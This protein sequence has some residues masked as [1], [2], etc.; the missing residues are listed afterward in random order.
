LV[1]RT[2][3]PFNAGMPPATLVDSQVTPIERFFVRSHAPAPEIDEAAFRLS[4]GGA[5]EKTLGLSLGE[6]RDRFPKKTVVATLQCAGNRRAEL[7][8]VEPINDQVQ[9]DAD[10]IGNAEWGGVPLRE[11]LQAAGIGE[12]ALHAAFTGLDGV[13]E[14]GTTF[15][16]GG[17]VPIE[18][19][20]SAEVLLA[21]EMNGQPLPLD[22]GAP[23]R[24]V[25]PGYIGARSVKWL[26]SISLQAEPS[27]N[28]YQ[29]RAYKI[30][31]PHVRADT[32]DWPNGLMLGELSVTSAICRP[33]AGENVA[34]SP[35]TVQ[36]YAAAGGGRLVERVEVS[37]DGGESWAVANLLGEPNRWAW[38]LWE[39]RLDLDPGEH[40]LI[41]RAWDS[42]ANT[43]P[44]DVRKIWNFKGYMNNAWHRVTVNVAG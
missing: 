6:L 17:S 38:R 27:D 2:E 21:Y 42:A 29:A 22:H 34:I 37:V 40:E 12:G 44:E 24:V 28:H 26:G 13:Q 20:M 25:V 11:V 32:A 19:A 35:V 4:V 33:A 10:P 23:L 36:G 41:S 30:F 16:F 31:P 1:V 3:T 8:A 15:G 9:W 39:I 18:K 7:S 14:K 43:Q 5:T